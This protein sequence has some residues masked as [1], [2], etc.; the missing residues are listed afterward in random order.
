M[1]VQIRLFRWFAILTILVTL[2]LVALGLFRLQDEIDELAETKRAGPTW[3]ANQME[4]ELLR[5]TQ[6]LARFAQ[7]AP[8]VTPDNV[9]FRFDILWSR[10]A[11]AVEGQSG[12]PAA[13]ETDEAAVLDALGDE[14]RRQEASVIDLSPG[15]VVEA[16]R[17]LAVFLPYGDPLHDYTLAAKDEQAAV[18]LAARSD[19]AFYSQISVYLSLAMG[20]ASL[21]LA[22]Q[23]FVESRFH[24]R[25]SMENAELLEKSQAAYRAKS[26]F[27]ATV[28]HELRTPVTSIKGTLGLI[29]GGML[30]E[31][32]D[33]MRRMVEIAHG[34]SERLASM[35]NDIL[36]FEKA[37]SGELSYRFEIL[38]LVTVVDEAV[39]ANRDFEAHRRVSVVFERPAGPIWV[40][41]DGFRLV[42][43]VANLL[44][45]AVKFSEPG[46]EV[47]VGVTK[48]GEAARVSVRDYG[49]GI[50][51]DFKR[52]VFE[53]FT[54]A[55]SSDTRKVGGTGLGMSISRAIAENHN[56]RVHFE[57][58]IGMGSTFY[59][60]IPLA[61]Q[62]AVAHRD[63]A[64]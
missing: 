16:E 36:D 38:D 10:H 37:E 43:L 1:L 23:F 3:I 64:A 28:S 47:I 45:N 17:L 22:V 58:K 7:G 25:I 53:R 27:L 29:K 50:P 2:C 57:S 35:I 15:D 44:S 30:G 19:L 49:S 20:V 55:D 31:L 21:I 5:F 34:N 13:A 51:D 62:D 54:Q 26:Q 48:V 59:F 46:Q 42:Q 52:R 11:V 14:L 12:R 24:K 60:D 18:A 6:A 56:G 32:S 39:E 33:K 8:E 9:V 40:D 61:P 4:F 63:S 41:G